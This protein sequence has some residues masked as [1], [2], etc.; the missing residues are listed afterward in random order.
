MLRSMDMG[1]Y[2]E[3]L[4]REGQNPKKYDEGGL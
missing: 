1:L 4:N 2:R 3:A